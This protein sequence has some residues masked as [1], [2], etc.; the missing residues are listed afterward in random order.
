[1]SGRVV[2]DIQITSRRQVSNS[3]CHRYSH[4]KVYQYSVSTDT[5]TRGLYYIYK[6]VHVTQILRFNWFLSSLIIHEF[7]SQLIKD[8]DPFYISSNDILSVYVRHSVLQACFTKS[9]I[10]IKIFAFSYF[11]RQ[12]V[13][14]GSCRMRYYAIFS[15]INLDFIFTTINCVLTSQSI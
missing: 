2:S 10:L 6:G 4:C 13:K 7:H 1:M 3:H 8:C 14:K 15:V 9:T 5:A 12:G 11:R